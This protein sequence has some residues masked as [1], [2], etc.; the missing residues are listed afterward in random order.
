MNNLKIR[1]LVLGMVLLGVCSAW[2]YA[3][4]DPLDEKG[5]RARALLKNNA[6]AGPRYQVLNI[7]NLA[8]WF[9]ADGTGSYPPS[10]SGDGLFYPR[11]TGSADYEDGLMWGAKAY[12]DAAKTLPA[13]YGQPYRVG[14]NEYPSG[15]QEGR[16]IGTGSAAVADNANGAAVYI[17]RIR[18]DYKVIPDDDLTRDAAESNEISVSQVNAS[19]KQKVLDQYALDW[20]TWP[21][22]YGAPYVERNGTPGYQA[23][24]A[25]NY[26]A[27]AG[28]LFTAESLITQ[29]KDEPG[30]AGADPNIVADQVVWTV[31]NDLNGSLTKALYG[32]EPLGLETQVTLWGYK[33]TDAL[34]NI[35]FKRFKF[36]N[37]GG[38]DTSGT[39]QKGSF[40]LDSM[41]V[42]QW[43]DID[44]GNAGDDVVGCDTAL[45]MGFVYNSNPVDAEYR[46][47]GLPP[48]L[49]GFDFLA[50]PAV[51]AAPGDSA[52]VNLKR[53][54]G[55]KNLPMTSFAFF[56]AGS[57]ISDPRPRNWSTGSY[58]WYQM[59][60]GFAPV[61]SVGSPD[62]FYP[63]PPGQTANK[64]PF[65]GDPTKPPSNTN[66][67]DGQGLQYSFS[68]GDRRIILGCGPF[69]L[70]P[71]DTNEVVVAGVVGL[72]SDRLSSVSVAKF[73]DIFAQN[74]YNA[75]FVV[76]SAPAPSAR[77][78]ELDREIIIDW[79]WDANK[80]KATEVATLSPGGF[81]F[82][83]YNV[84]AMPNAS[85]PLNRGKKIATYDVINNYG[86]LQD[87]D[88]DPS[89]GLVLTKP[90]QSGSNSGVER[91][92][93]VKTDLL[94]DLPALN[95]GQDYYFAI[96][97]YFRAT[98][99]GFL[100]AVLESPPARI[101]ARPQG[102]VP[103]TTYN[104][105]VGDGLPAATHATGSS[106]GTVSVDV[107]DP[108]RLTS[109]T[110]RLSFTGTATSKTYSITNVTK[111]TTV[112]TGGRGLGVEWGGT[113]KDFPTADGMIVHVNDPVGVSQ[114]A[115]VWTGKATPVIAGSTLFDGDGYEGFGGGV[116]PGDEA[117]NYF[118]A[119]A[120]STIK[121]NGIPVM[122][123]FDSVGQKAYRLLRDANR[124]NNSYKIGVGYALHLTTLAG[125]IAAGVANDT[126]YGTGTTFINDFAFGGADGSGSFAPG[127]TLRVD[128]SVGGTGN[129]RNFTVSRVYSDTKLRL[130]T[131][132]VRVFAGQAPIRR[133]DEIFAPKDTLDFVHI[134]FS[135]WDISN[136]S[137]PRQLNVS[138]RDPGRDG[139][140]TPGV[141]VDFFNIYNT[142]YDPAGLTFGAPGSLAQKTDNIATGGPAADII[143]ICDFTSTATA[144]VTIN[145]GSVTRER[146]KPSTGDTGRVWIY[147]RIRFSATDTY[148]WSPGTMAA[149]FGDAA[150]AKAE[151]AK[152][153]VFPNPYYAFNPQETSRFVR[154]VTFN[155]LPANA[156][157]RI[158]N[159][160]GHLVKTIIKDAAVNS[161]QFQRWDLLNQY[162]FPVASGVYIA[163]IDMPDLGATKVVKIAVIQEQEVLDAY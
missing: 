4:E 49:S 143:Y 8:Q 76:P 64:F 97:A 163:H 109:D 55:K 83:G 120:P 46:G 12:R 19:Q 7:N 154:F 30:V 152:I 104:A 119:Y 5:K 89:S 130:S 60:K 29:N 102:P 131:V 92:Y 56:S 80:I 94:H 110:Y 162:D 103:G 157:I 135:A 33:R 107:V 108:S 11:G 84:Y 128:T 125:T 112:F 161:T 26:D 146:I 85:A 2:A 151:V 50:G 47:F 145:G 22:A 15:N 113:T 158:F 39:L 78:A 159:I 37:K 51:A 75:L 100:P 140:W 129:Y 13:P 24:P 123:K 65:A 88:F 48:P 90:V 99:P 91:V 63:F 66:F 98:V 27:N 133:G 45:G 121:T 138:F 54:Y 38:V 72:G 150:V 118:G 1:F 134:P 117:G 141:V 139:E 79:G 101:S 36:I 77:A 3:S 111:S 43:A 147:P 32:S 115:S 67:L 73:N 16:I 87:Q 148:T 62:Q 34:G 20:T 25:F 68:G 59:L 9:R 127:T 114:T 106:E 23:P 14:G 122:L 95:N 18:R 61:G 149:Q 156:T 57:A 69:S 96:S 142:T 41:Y 81:A 17:Y 105:K 10:G 35:F 155:H 137:V 124:T 86:V 52:V 126:I 28:P 82:E 144:S 160:A 42:A 58:R 74:T 6:P 153:N 132:P 31:Y 40:W 116:L 71:G 136:P 70:N 21:V 53:V 44:L 93:D